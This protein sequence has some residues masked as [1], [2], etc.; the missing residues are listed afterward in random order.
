MTKFC[1]NCGKELKENADVC[2]NCGVLVNK[3]NFPTNIKT[4][5]PGK[6]LSIASMIIG[7][8]SLLITLGTL[9][10]VTESTSINYYNNNLEF[11]IDIFMYICLSTTGLIFSII[12]FKKQKNGFNISG[13]ILNIISLSMILLTIIFLSYVY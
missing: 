1:S 3:I 13:L 11:Y 12:G 8:V 7:I 10:E 5:T 4:K 9:S 6:G 2:L